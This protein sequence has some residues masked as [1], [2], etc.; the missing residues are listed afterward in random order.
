[1]GVQQTPISGEPAS[2][3]S[4]SYRIGPPWRLSGLFQTKPRARRSGYWVWNPIFCPA[5]YCWFCST[6]LVG[7]EGSRRRRNDEHGKKRSWTS[8]SGL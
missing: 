2:N 5:G 1:M 3:S 6:V 4:A 8:V 7:D